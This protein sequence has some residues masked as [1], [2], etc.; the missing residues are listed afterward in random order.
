[1][2]GELATVASFTVCAAVFTISPGADTLLV[3]THG[4]RS[5][6]RAALF[7]ALGVNTGLIC[8]ATLSVVGLTA[9]LAT[10]PWA[11]RSIQVVGAVYLVYLGAAGLIR[12]RAASAPTSAPPPAAPS[13]HAFRRGLCTNLLNPKVGIF[14]VSLLPQF[15]PPS[16]RGPV[17]LLTLAAVHLLLSVVWLGAIGW[18]S[19]RAARSLSGHTARFLDRI[20]A[21]GLIGVGVAI[22]GASL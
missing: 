8:W 17:L 6:R 15:A 22:A 21:V 19:A 11:Y 13:A 16:Q 1:M 3:L 10:V 5:G 7:C 4:L 2:T 14:Y 18:T 9:L 12:R 20:G